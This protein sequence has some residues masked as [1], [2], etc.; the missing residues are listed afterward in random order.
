MAF[1]GNKVS[2]ELWFVTQLSQVDHPF[3]MFGGQQR[4]LVSVCCLAS[5]FA[6]GCTINPCLDEA[7][8]YG[9]ANKEVICYLD[10]KIK[11][12]PHMKWYPDSEVKRFERNY[13]H[14]I[15]EGPYREWYSNG[16]LKVEANYRKGML[17]GVYRKYYS[18]GAEW[19]VARYD[20]NIRV[21]IYTEFYKNTSPLIAKS[22]AKLV[23]N[24]NPLGKPEGK[25][26]RYRMNGNPTSEYTYFEGKLVGKRLWKNDGRQA[27]VLSNL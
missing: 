14:D 18:N 27:P 12:G 7:V 16:K 10:K 15:L 17:S 5:F 19:V 9:Q 2:D 20:D 6:V 23:Y 1:L 11:H 3:K 25:Q 21:G 8:L 4:V 22:Q 26:T 24:F 13:D